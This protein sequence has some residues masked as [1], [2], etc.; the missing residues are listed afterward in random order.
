MDPEGGE[1]P[2]QLDISDLGVDLGGAGQPLVLGEDPLLD[3]VAA[4]VG[5]RQELLQAGMEKEHLYLLES[6]CL[7]LWEE[8]D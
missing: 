4:E 6:V 7:C 1:A 2:G 8:V 5:L 3:L